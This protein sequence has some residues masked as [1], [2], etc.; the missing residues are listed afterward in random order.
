MA[1]EASAT[2]PKKIPKGMRGDDDL[3][4]KY[5]Q[6]PAFY[7]HMPRKCMGICSPDQG[8]ELLDVLHFRL[9]LNTA[10]KGLKY[11]KIALQK[12]VQITN[13]DRSL[14]RVWNISE[15]TLE[16][17]AIVKGI[18]DFFFLS[19]VFQS[20]IAFIGSRKSAFSAKLSA[21]SITRLRA[22]SLIYPQRRIFGGHSPRTIDNFFYECARRSASH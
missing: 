3:A 16:E 6:F 17:E 1:I 13:T 18:F 8:G 22:P 7:P 2:S 4:R 12:H 14:F 15:E 11:V 20:L 9:Y 19:Q 5:P 21:F 10:S